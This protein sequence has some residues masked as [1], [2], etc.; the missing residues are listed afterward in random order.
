M[1]NFT[2]RGKIKIQGPF[3]IHED[4]IKD[5]EKNCVFMNIILSCGR[6]KAICCDDDLSYMCSCLGVLCAINSVRKVF[7]LFLLYIPVVPV[8]HFSQYIF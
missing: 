2:L 6:R 5:L 8:K 4:N 7:T 1:T 3:I